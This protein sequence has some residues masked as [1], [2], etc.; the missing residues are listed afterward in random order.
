MNPLLNDGK[1]KHVVTSVMLGGEN[2]FM[3]TLKEK[4]TSCFAIVVIPK[5]EPIEKPKDKG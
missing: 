5:G 1:E 4:D 2:E 3:E